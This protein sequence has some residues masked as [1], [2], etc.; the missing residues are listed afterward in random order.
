MIRHHRIPAFLVGLLLAPTLCHAAP[1][2]LGPTGLLYVPTASVLSRMEIDGAF[3]TT[4]WARGD[5]DESLA[6]LRVALGLSGRKNGGKEIALARVDARD[7]TGDLTLLSFKMR[8]SGVISNGRFAAGMITP[9]EGN[10]PTTFYGVGSTNL[11]RTL[12]IHY[13]VGLNVGARAGDE[14]FFGSVDDR[15]EARMLFFFLG[16]EKDWRKWKLD[17][18]FDGDR[19]TWGLNYFVDRRL[20]LDFFR[21]G[22]GSREERASFRPRLGFG[23]TYRF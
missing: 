20:S 18:E 5:D 19:E 22:E 2:L 15:G 12:A 7:S 10:A 4:R 9:L 8:L 14:S 3:S 6:H 21:I 1:G 13:G 16:A 23:A 11:A 17:F